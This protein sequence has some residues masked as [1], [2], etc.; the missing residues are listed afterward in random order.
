MIRTSIKHGVV[1]VAAAAM[2]AAAVPAASTT[3]PNRARPSAAPAAAAAAAPGLFRIPVTGALLDGPA[4]VGTVRGQILKFSN[5][6]SGILMASTRMTARMLTGQ[7]LTVSRWVKV[8][9]VNALAKRAGAGARMPG[10]VA[11]Q[12]PTACSILHLVLG[13]LDLNI[14]GLR[15]QLN[16]VILDITAIP[17]AGNL[18]GNLLC[19]IA[20]LFDAGGFLRNIAVL[21]NQ[22][23]AILNR[24]N[25]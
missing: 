18:L 22:L 8:R 25:T 2:L 23:L 14:L 6:K 10:A 19:S 15:V 7:T 12:V 24:L 13:P 4:R 3:A 1:A 20:G 21:L 11:A 16:Q 17:G 5:G 9:D